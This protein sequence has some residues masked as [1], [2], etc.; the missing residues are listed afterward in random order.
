MV[1]GV[2]FACFSFSIWGSVFERCIEQVEIQGVIEMK[3]HVLLLFVSVN[4]SSLYVSGISQIYP[5]Y[6]S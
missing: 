1:S 5:L 4:I 3:L 2:P 6:K